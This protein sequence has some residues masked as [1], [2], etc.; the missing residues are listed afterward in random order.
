MSL[1]CQEKD[2]FF[3]R[4]P[5]DLKNAGVKMVMP[6]LPTLFAEASFDKLGNE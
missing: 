5:F 4:H 2:P 3:M 6:T 1:V